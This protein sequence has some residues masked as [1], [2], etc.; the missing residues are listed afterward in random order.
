MST[1]DRCAELQS[2]ADSFS[3]LAGVSKKVWEVD[4]QICPHCQAEM[5]IL[6]FIIERKVTRNIL[7]HLKC[8]PG[9]DIR[10]SPS[11]AGQLQP[12]SSL[13]R[14]ERHYELVDDGWPGY[15]EP[16]YNRD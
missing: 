1:D 8:W 3:A 13:S 11:W 14:H 15:E 6:G 9:T 7:T 12:S 10:G 5:K 16:V 4:P 2:A